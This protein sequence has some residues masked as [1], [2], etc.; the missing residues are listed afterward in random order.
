MG[1][2]VS[3]EQNLG[4]EFSD[5]TSSYDFKNKRIGVIG[6]GSSAIQII[7]SL[8]KVSG[9]HLSCFVRSKTWISRPFGNVAMRNLGIEETKCKSL[10]QPITIP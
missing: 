6:G 1:Q 2:E 5:S 9:T 4:I 7:P 8:Q 3:E 10:Y